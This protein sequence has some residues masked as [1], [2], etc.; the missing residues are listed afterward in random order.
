MC[1]SVA[2]S[3]A[4]SLSFGTVIL[5]GLTASF[6]SGQ[7]PGAARVLGTVARSRSAQTLGSLTGV[8]A[9]SCSV[10]RCLPEPSDAAFVGWAGWV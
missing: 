5:S 2:A 6:P 10:D 7:S 1:R 9:G 4:R 8:V 3:D